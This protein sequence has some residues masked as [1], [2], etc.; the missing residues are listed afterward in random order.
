MKKKKPYFE[1]NSDYNPYDCSSYNYTF[2]NGNI[3]YEWGPCICFMFASGW[4][5]SFMRNFV[6]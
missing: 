6:F 5:Y 3:D 2:V 1:I 4:I